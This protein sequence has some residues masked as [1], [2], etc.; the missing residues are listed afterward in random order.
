MGAWDTPPTPEEMKA[1]APSGDPWATPP[2]PE[3][4]QSSRVGMGD[5]Q[6][7][8]SSFPDTSNVPVGA[9]TGDP[10]T[11]R[12][13]AEAAAASGGRHSATPRDTAGLA[14]LT[15]GGLASLIPGVGPAIG[16]GAL[17]SAGMKLGDPG[18]SASDVAASAAGGGAVGGGIYKG[19][20]L[21]ADLL[22]AAAQ[23]VAPRLHQGALEWGRKALTGN[24]GAISVKKPLSEEAVQAAYDTGAIKPFGAIQGTAERLGVTREALGEEYAQIVAA[25]EAKGVTGPNAILLAKKMVEEGK[26]VAAKSLGSPAP[27]MFRSV[28][29]E[30]SGKVDPTPFAPKRLGLS[31]AED[32]KRTLQQAARGEYV[33]EGP[34]SL[35]GEAKKDLASMLRQAVEDSVAEQAGKAPVEAAAFV[36]VKQRLGSIIEA[37]TAADTAAARAAR[38]QKFG[39][40]SKVLAGGT[41]ATGN[42]PGAAATLFAADAARTRGPSTMG[43]AY[44]KAAG[45]AESLAE[46]LARTRLRDVSAPVGTSTAAA[47]GDF[48][49]GRFQLAGATAG[50]TQRSGTPEQSAAAESATKPPNHLEAI[51]ANPRAAPYRALFE[52]A[53]QESP[54]AAS[55]LHAEL[56]EKDP[57]YRAAVSEVSK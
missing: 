54:G 14:L 15:A 39:L 1:V 3:E 43:W 32:M 20:P 9:L 21:V 29:E 44:N 48:A 11:D 42:V 57:N 30:L 5:V 45:G 26:Q 7:S 46:Y 47:T 33:K 6:A 50:D 37:S 25:L 56:Y 24:A 40:G 4:V 17:T 31:Q 19:L 53:A 52:R 51:R 27:G 2:T 12:R 28:A 18:A 49:A 22:G 13:I 8:P 38:N 55:R 41:L 16:G 10:A 23:K 35:A 36:P 34:T